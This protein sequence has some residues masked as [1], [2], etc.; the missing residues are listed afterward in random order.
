MIHRQCISSWEKPFSAPFILLV[1]LLSTFLV[2]LSGQSTTKITTTNTTTTSTTVDGS[3]IS[4]FVNTNRLA[5]GKEL[6][7][8]RGFHYGTEQP[9]SAANLTNIVASTRQDQYSSSDK[10]E[11]PHPD[12]WIS[13]PSNGCE[14]TKEEMEN[15][16]Y[17]GTRAK[18]GSTG[19]YENEE[20]R[21]DDNVDDDDDED[22]MDNDDDYNHSAKKDKYDKSDDTTAPILAATS[23][24]EAA[25]P[26][27]TIVSLVTSEPSVSPEMPLSP[28]VEMATS[29]PTTHATSYVNTMNSTSHEVCLDV[30][31]QDGPTSDA[32]TNPSGVY[33]VR[34]SVQYRNE[35][36]TTQD[37]G[38]YLDIMNM[39]MA[40]W[41]ADCNKIAMGYFFDELD[42][43]S[44]SLQEDYEIRSK[45]QDRSIVYAEWDSWKGKGTSGFR[46][47][48]AFK[49]CPD[50][51][52]IVVMSR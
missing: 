38:T 36:I 39:P 13:S 50:L 32:S 12:G 48:F 14:T 18:K 4:E 40:L 9:N 20:T 2:S 22:D 30:E 6:F 37:I 15:G 7:S 46:S 17:D 5:G 49:V 28:Q 23:D 45:V 44:R 24:N 31:K 16:G 19:C 27:P 11:V 51:V 33:L 8:V 21:L 43:H 25:W 47:R 35:I 34:T 26:K 52:L 1:L 3:V 29:F 10:T 41:M 42:N